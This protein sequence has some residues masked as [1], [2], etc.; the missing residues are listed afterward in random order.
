[1]KKKIDINCDMGESYYDKKIG[2]DSKIMPFITSSNIACGF[3][4]GD[5]NTIRKTIELAIEYDVKIGAHPS[6]F[7]LE[8]FGRRKINLELNELESIILYQV[9]ALKGIT[10][11][12]GKKLHH[13]KPHGALYNMA[14]INDDI[15]ETI[16]LT[17]KKIDPNL[18]LYGPSKMKWKE[19]SK[20]HKIEYVSEVFS[21]RN[22]ND[23]LTLVDRNLENSMITHIRELQNND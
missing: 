20:K 10:E 16:V 19:I 7:D 5:P 21:D 12:Y 15:A 9:S 4:G 14:S 17:I 2:N 6:Y 23:N 11:S 3:H 18:K 22:Y 8:G 13:V 1:M